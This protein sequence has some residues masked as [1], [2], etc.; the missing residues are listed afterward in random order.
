MVFMIPFVSVWISSRISF[1]FRDFVW[2]V[3][4]SRGVVATRKV[5]PADFRVAPVL[6][7]TQPCGHRIEAYLVCTD[8]RRHSLSQPCGRFTCCVTRSLHLTEYLTS[9]P[10]PQTSVLRRGQSCGHRMEIHL[11]RTDGRRHSL[12]QPCGL[13]TCCVTRSIHL[14]GYLT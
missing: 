13:S 1:D 9:D 3:A 4:I 6:R 10:R 11:V 7:R 2:L 14:T 5:A 8:G 12:S